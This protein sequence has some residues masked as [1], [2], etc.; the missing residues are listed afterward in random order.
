MKE[1]IIS[2][3]EA[4]NWLVTSEKLPGFT[5]KGRT[6]KEAMDKLPDSK[7]KHNCP[8]ARLIP[9]KRMDIH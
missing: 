4:G 2:Q 1:F 3:D 9:L 8:D 6:Q 7:S 5:A